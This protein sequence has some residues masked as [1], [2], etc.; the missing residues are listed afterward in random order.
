MQY[1]IEWQIEKLRDKLKSNLLISSFAITL[2]CASSLPASAN[3]EIAEVVARFRGCDY[4]IAD[5]PN[6]LYVLEWYG[7]YDPDV[8]DRLYGAISS[9]GMKDVIYL[10]SE[11]VGRVWVEDYMESETAALDEIADHC[12]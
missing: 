10:P 1:V 11:L 2:I 7:G 12:N 6:G 4:F 3:G 8:G 5:G 9:Y